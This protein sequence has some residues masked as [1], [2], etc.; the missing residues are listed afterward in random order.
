MNIFKKLLDR[1][2]K[3]AL[4]GLQV[5]GLTAVVGAAGV[6]AWQYLSAPAEAPA[7]NLPQYNPG[8]VMYVSTAANGGE[9]RGTS[10]AADGTESPTTPSSMRFSTRNFKQLERSEIAAKAA[11]EMAENESYAIPE[12]PAAGEG[13]GASPV[14]G[15]GVD[16]GSMAEGLGMG[17]NALGA[18]AFNGPGGLGGGDM[19]GAMAGIQNMVSGAMQQGQGAGGGPNGAP[20]KGGP[21]AGQGGEGGGAGAA[22]GPKLA[23]AAPGWKGGGSGSGGGNGGGSSFVIQDSG[24]NKGMAKW[25][26]TPN[27]VPRG[28]FLKLICGLK[29]FLEGKKNCR[30]A[31]MLYC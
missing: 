23:S 26:P 9:Y 27:G 3:M 20:G 4:S 13:G 15:S 25:S 21:G 31:V 28:P 30:R 8:E 5:A 1:A 6:G 7:F 29:N 19:A 18:D 14:G 24:K 10:F 2:G 17:A 11:E 16:I 22:G 12:E